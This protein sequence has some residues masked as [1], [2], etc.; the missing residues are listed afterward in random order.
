MYLLLVAF[1]K[2]LIF[3]NFPKLHFLYV[4]QYQEVFHKLLLLFGGELSHVK[5]VGTILD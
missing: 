2:I 5:V 1:Y 3:S 4:M